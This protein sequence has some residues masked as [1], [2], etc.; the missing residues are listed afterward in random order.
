M[1]MSEEEAWVKAYPI[2]S[3]EDGVGEKDWPAWKALTGGDK[4]QLVGDDLFVADPAIAGRRGRGRQL[5]ARE[6]QPDRD[7]HG[8][9]RLHGAAY[10][11]ERP[12][13]EPP[14]AGGARDATIADLAV[15]TGYGQIK[16]GSA[17]RAPTAWRS[18]GLLRIEEELGPMA[19]FAGAR[20]S[21]NPGAEARGGACSSSS[22]EIF[23]ERRVS[24][25][26]SSWTGSL[27]HAE[28]EGG[29]PPRP[30]GCP[31]C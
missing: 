29:E 22:T 17:C 27:F 9:A 28:V 13:D 30:R 2:V 20:R 4:I 21:R 31:S 19:R 10:R 1:A 11:G 6:G 8:V 26:S 7:L 14:A 25:A 18:N 5:R 12:V 16:T 23:S 24:A 3:L 15:A